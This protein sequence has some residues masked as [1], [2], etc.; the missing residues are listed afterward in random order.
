MTQ[1]TVKLC[2]DIAF[3]IRREDFFLVRFARAFFVRAFA[4]AFD[5]LVASSFRCSGV[6]LANRAFPPFLPIMEK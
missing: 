3:Y 5:A 2:E 4:A 1:V 6:I